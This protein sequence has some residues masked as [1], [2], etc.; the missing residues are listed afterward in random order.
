MIIRFGKAFVRRIHSVR[1]FKNGTIRDFDS[2]DKYMNY[3][4]GRKI[5]KDGFFKVPEA[6]Q[7]KLDEMFGK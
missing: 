6:E 1:V 4:Y 3:A 5:D 2:V 7:M